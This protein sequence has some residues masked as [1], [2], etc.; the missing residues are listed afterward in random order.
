MRSI[1]FQ[2]CKKRTLL[3]AGILVVSFL[4]AG[5]NYPP[6]TPT[7]AAPPAAEPG[8]ADPIDE[9]EPADPID[10]P[11]SEPLASEFIPID[12]TWRLYR[13]YELGFEM[14]IPVMMVHGHA[15]CYWNDAD[16]DHS[17]R[18]QA[19]LVPVV[20][21]EAEDRVYITHETYSVLT[22]ETVEGGRHFYGG[23]EQR[24]MN[25]EA[26]QA[27]EFPVTA[28]EITSRPVDSDE[29]LLEIVHDV[30]GEACGLGEIM[31]VE[32]S[33]YSR[34][35]VASDG[36]PMEETECFMNY[37]YYFYYHAG[38]GQAI[39]WPFG[40]AYSFYADVSYM[41]EPYDETMIESFNFLGD[42]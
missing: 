1:Q 24:E 33:E 15:G 42:S 31:P 12:D 35:S 26:L 41:E 37:A 16:G 10:E 9:A 27:G 39:T 5:C 30:Y 3:C 17:Y 2:A 28:W 29:D 21:F 23:C 32:G 13:N 6:P 14:M 11:E 20:V 36:L 38:L 8:S 7:E 34:V 22:E 25:L 18:P 19:G 4:A 40:Q